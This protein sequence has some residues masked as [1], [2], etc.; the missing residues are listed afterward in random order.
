[1]NLL[2]ILSK[3]TDH[4]AI[5]AKEQPISTK[6]I[7]SGMLAITLEDKERL[8]DEVSRLREVITRNQEELYADRVEIRMKNKK[9]EELKV[10]NENFRKELKQYKAFYE[11]M[12]S[13]RIEIEELFN[14]AERE[15]NCL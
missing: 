14:A 10:K 8:E 1:M 13:H 12:Y 11:Y 4:D 9:I 6:N 5:E 3:K 15:K 7:E 2:K